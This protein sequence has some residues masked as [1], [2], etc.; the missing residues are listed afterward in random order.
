MSNEVVVFDLDGTLLD[1]DNKVIGGSQTLKCLTTLKQMGCTLAICTGRLDHDIIKVEQLYDLDIKHR[2]SQNG[3]VINQ[4]NHF[5]AILLDKE[6]GIDIY[7]YLLDKDIRI[8]LNTVSNRYW[9]SLRDPEFPSELYDSHIIRGDYEEIILCQPA[10]LFLVI[11]EDE[12]LSQIEQ[13]INSHYQYTKAVK[14][15]TTSLEILHCNAS[16]GH[17]VE[18]L[19]SDCDVYA[20]GDSPNDFDMFDVVKEGYLV[21]NIEC[22]YECHK[23]A[24]ILEALQDIIMKIQK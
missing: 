19:Y 21:S 13:Y 6:E 18:T 12:T 8:E 16:K 22:Q 3:A 15:S 23:K 5:E 7:R 1:G 11:G 14:T 24:T 2:I 20:I 17:A 9:K 10:V 4:D